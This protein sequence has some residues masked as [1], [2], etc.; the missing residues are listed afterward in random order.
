MQATVENLVFLKT[1]LPEGSTW[2]LCTVGADIFVLGPVAIA[3]G[4]HVRVGLEDT[5][6]VAKGKLAQSNAEIVSKIAR[7]ANDMGRE[8]ATPQETRKI[9]NLER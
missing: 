9:L 7:I 6:L 3:A 4:G 5:V 8:I 2:S 1:S